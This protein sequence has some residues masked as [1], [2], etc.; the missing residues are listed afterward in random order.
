M[1]EISPK[2]PHRFLKERTALNDKKLRTYFRL[3]QSIS[4]PSIYIHGYDKEDAE[5]EH[6]AE[7]INSASA[8]W[9]T[10]SA[11]QEMLAGERHKDE[12]VL[13]M[14]KEFPYI[15]ELHP[16]S[17]WFDGSTSFG[18]YGIRQLKEG[19]AK[20]L[21][22]KVSNNNIEFGSGAYMFTPSVCVDFCEEALLR[23]PAEVRL[24]FDLNK[25]DGN[26]RLPFNDGSFDSATMPVIMSY[27]TDWQHFFKEV[28]RILTPRASAFIL[29]WENAGGT[30]MHEDGVSTWTQPGPRPNL[31]AYLAE[32]NKLG[33]AHRAENLTA[34]D[35]NGDMF[36]LI[37]VSARPVRARKMK[38]DCAEDKSDKSTFEA[39]VIEFYQRL[40]GRGIEASF[41][42]PSWSMKT[43]NKPMH[44]YESAPVYIYFH[45][46]PEREEE[47]HTQTIKEFKKFL[48]DKEGSVSFYTGGH[49]LFDIESL[50]DDTVASFQKEIDQCVIEVGYNE[51]LKSNVI[52]GKATE[53]KKQAFRRLMERVDKYKLYKTL[54]ISRENIY[55]NTEII[56]R[57][58]LFDKENPGMQR[59]IEEDSEPVY[60]LWKELNKLNK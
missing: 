48:M 21:A 49:E 10:L 23:N 2:I 52:C 25:I 8:R 16:F 34:F 20:Y 41:I 57:G 45:D 28:F 12:A 40:K 5:Y 3:T 35:G 7:T 42:L 11:K 15:D 60:Q 46:K 59:A 22:R 6:V 43:G 32:L 26:T 17:S 37:E 1:P 50:L 4:E 58:K 47:L 38:S 18:L 14:M 27:I 24:L 29:L 53:L 33:Y 31:G 54:L 39:D 30:V 13:T 51:L 55:G 36:K 9:K 19:M 56:E 44:H